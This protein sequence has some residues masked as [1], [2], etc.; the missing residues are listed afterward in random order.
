VSVWYNESTL[1][2]DFWFPGGLSILKRNLVI[3]NLRGLAMLGVIGIHIGTFVLSSS[4]PGLGLFLLLQIFTRFAVPAFFFISGYGLFCNDALNKPLDYVASVRHHLRTV[5][6]PYLVWSLF[7]IWLWQWEDMIRPDGTFSPSVLFVKLLLG[8]GCYHIYFLVILLGFYLTLPLWRWLV[9]L[10]DRPFRV[11]TAACLAVLAGLQLWLY[12]WN[13][14]YWTY[15][16][17]TAQYKIILRLLNERINYIPLF[18]GFVFVLGGWC[19]IHEDA[20][21]DWLRSHLVV[22]LI[23]FAASCAVYL[24]SFYGYLAQG[25]KLAE[26]PG[27]LTQLTP[28]GLLYTVCWIFFF[29]AVLGTVCRPAPLVPEGAVGLFHGHLPDSPVLSGA[30]VHLVR[31]VR[32]FVPAGSRPAFLCSR[33]GYIPGS[34]Y[35]HSCAGT[36]QQSLRAARPGPPPLSKAPGHKKR[37]GAGEASGH[38]QRV[39]T[40]RVE[41]VF[42]L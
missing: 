37:P 39:L 40:K 11:G 8:E 20:M 10:I 7:Y 25:M 1:Y 21:R 19:A 12:H 14:V 3:D 36:A 42:R 23:A 33:P 29:C 15:P 38:R 28:E 27:H 16:S 18:Y 30:V 31:M 6:V 13:A 34:G 4:T 26:I 2:K 35:C 9:R 17:W 41:R 32:L 5:G 22:T 24:H